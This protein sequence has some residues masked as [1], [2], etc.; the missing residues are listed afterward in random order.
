MKHV[1][2]LASVLAATTAMAL[3]STVANAQTNAG[4][5]PVT[6]AA[7]GGAGESAAASGQLVLL[8]KPGQASLDAT[9]E[10]I[11]DKASR[12]YR[13]GKPIIMIVTGSSDTT[14]SPTQN[15]LL[16]QRRA[17]VVA[18]GMADRDIP[19]ERT[20]ILAKGVTNLPVET[21]AGVSEQQNRRVEITW[22]LGHPK[23]SP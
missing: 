17:D 13:E 3:A 9:N 14:G 19:S 5:T 1:A 18:Q 20:Q 7:P 10:A 11:L 21:G 6:A 4:S 15:L 16:S 8:F 2:F 22:R 23:P 12:L